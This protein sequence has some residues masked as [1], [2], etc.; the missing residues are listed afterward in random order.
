M[1]SR[2]TIALD[3]SKLDPSIFEKIK[4]QIMAEQP[5]RPAYVFGVG[6]DSKPKEVSQEEFKKIV[7]KPMSTSGTSNTGVGFSG[8]GL[9]LGGTSSEQKLAF[10]QQ[11]QQPIRLEQKLPVQVQPVQSQT[12]PA[13]VQAQETKNSFQDQ[14]PRRRRPENHESSGQQMVKVVGQVVQELQAL[15]LTMKQ[16]LDLVRKN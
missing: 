6:N 7:G 5:A 4:S 10:Q 2:P 11:A 1:S 16:I 14:G 3:A 13:Q 15:N 9:G 8:L 12:Q